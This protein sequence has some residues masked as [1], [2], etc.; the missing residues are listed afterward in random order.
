MKPV[1]AIADWCAVDIVGERGALQRLAVA[2]LDPEKAEQARTLEERYP[3][4]PNASGGVHDVIRTGK[5]VFMS[6]IPAALLEAAALNEEHRR[7]L[8]ELNLTSYMCV[9]LLAHSKA[10]GA[11]TLVSAESGRVYGEGDL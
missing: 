6:R 7:V 11:I 3:S 9:P 2:H 10:F 1:P 8:T 5:P 4:D